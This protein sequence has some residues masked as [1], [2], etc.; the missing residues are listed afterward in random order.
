MADIYF[1]KA[2]TNRQKGAPPGS[3]KLICKSIQPDIYPPEIPVVVVK[4]TNRKPT[5]NLGIYS[6]I[7]GHMA[8]ENLQKWGYTA[9]ENHRTTRYK[10]WVFHC[11]P[12]GDEQHAM[13]NFMSNDG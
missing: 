4:Q 9:W 11:C 12:K 5:V 6:L 1:F 3:Y 8:R 7:I 13:V 2:V 10:W